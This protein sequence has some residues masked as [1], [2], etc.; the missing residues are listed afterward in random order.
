MGSLDRDSGVLHPLRSLYDLVRLELDEHGEASI[1]AAEQGV[2]IP[3][4]GVG[5]LP[6]VDADASESEAD[7][8]AG[9]LVLSAG[10]DG[11][12]VF[13]DL[14]S[15]ARGESAGFPGALRR[16][17]AARS[18]AEEQDEEEGGTPKP[19]TIFGEGGEQGLASHPAAA[20]AAETSSSPELPPQGVRGGVGAPLPETFGSISGDLAR[21]SYRK[22]KKKQA[23]FLATTTS[24]KKKSRQ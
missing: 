4:G 9:S 11:K 19:T 10:S 6:D 5:V 21:V 16:L 15:A 18:P 22:K 23:P 3:G 1:A 2:T 13:L 24:E 20:T 7:D 12:L 14:S 17:A 8:D